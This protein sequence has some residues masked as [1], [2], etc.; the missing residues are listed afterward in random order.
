LIVRQS[1]S[2]LALWEDCEEPN[3]SSAI[4]PER[5]PT[6]TTTYRHAVHRWFNF[7]AGFSP[8]FVTQC[9]EQERVAPSSILLDPFAGCATAPVAAC[10]KGFRAIGYEAHPVLARIARAKLPNLSTPS[11]AKRIFDVITSGLS[12]PVSTTSLALSP[13]VF[14]EKLFPLSSLECLLGARA[15]LKRA[16]ME[17]DD[18]AFLILSSMAEKCCHS[19]TDGIYK[20]PSSRKSFITPWQ[21]LESVFDVICTDLTMKGVLQYR[22]LG[23]IYEGDAASMKDV[24][25][26][27][28]GIVVTSPPYLNNFDFAEMTRMLLYFWEMASSW[29]DITDKVRSKLLV[30]TTTALKGHKPKQMMYRGN[31]P[32]RVH[33]E[34][35]AV[36]KSLADERIT[37]AGK[38]EYDF[39]VYPYFS[40]L[41]D[42][43]KEAYRC[44][45]PGGTT[46]IMISDAALYGIHI[47]APQ[48]LAELLESL[49]YV[50]CSCTL[51]RKRGHR[52]LLDKRDGS[53]I[54]LG[55]YL[56]RAQKPKLI[57]GTF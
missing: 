39:L 34:L 48:V 19:Q 24:A 41:S 50:D 16:N 44:L 1:N 26:D 43:F 12:C 28:V 32:V 3:A 49:G 9:L 8:E 13:R 18:L 46:H 37:R 11:L 10:H 57:R 5:L 20:A 17:D 23:T 33:A 51:V 47:S 31:L 55:E 14:L 27:S 52:W 15:A 2:Q 36:V 53:P 30:N 40:K 4:T 38:K 42:I 7:I 45:A 29:G 21:A 54:G 6:N 35:D 25:N 22:S 56:V